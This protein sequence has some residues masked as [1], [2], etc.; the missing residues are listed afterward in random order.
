MGQLEQEGKK[1]DSIVARMKAASP[2]ERKSLQRESE[3]VMERINQLHQDF[4]AARKPAPSAT[5]KP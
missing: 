5:P 1:L 3:Q 2:E 4:E